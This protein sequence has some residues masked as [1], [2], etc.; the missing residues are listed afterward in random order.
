MKNRDFR[1]GF[2]ILPALLIVYCLFYSDVYAQTLPYWIFFTDRGNIDSGKIIASKK[3]SPSEPKNSSRRAKVQ[4][5]KLF[6]ET[7]LPVNNEYIEAVRALPAKIRTITRYFN[8]VSAELDAS[9][10]EKVRNLPFVKEIIPVRELKKPLKPETPERGI[11]DTPQ[12]KSADYN[13]G[14]SFGQ[15]SLIKIPDLHKMGFLGE[16][17]RIAIFDS[18]FENLEHTAFDSLDVYAVRD[19]VDGDDNPYDDDHGTQVLSV[20]AALDKGKMIGAAPYAQYILARTENRESELKVEED[21][22]VAALE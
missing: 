15:L 5:G 3:I 1:F 7:D 19:F 2:L 11:I 13:Y 14:D 20:L 10:I 18:G 6:N 17:I 8:G 22:W 4:A 16:G 21:F 9:Q 12:K